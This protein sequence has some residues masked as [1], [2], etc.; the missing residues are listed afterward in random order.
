[1]TQEE[2]LANMEKC[3]R[4]QDCN[5]PK[6]PLDYYMEERVE[7]RGEERCILRGDRKSKRVKGIR[8]A[9]MRGISKFIWEK[10]RKL[11]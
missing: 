9:T 8:S 5:I 2:N 10:N 1:M 6:C 4:Y 11:A 3:P 7:L